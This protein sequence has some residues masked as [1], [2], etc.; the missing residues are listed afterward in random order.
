MQVVK[1]K[2]RVFLEASVS[3]EFHDASEGKCP[4]Q[5]F[6]ST[7]SVGRVIGF[8]SDRGKEP[9]YFLFVGGW[10]VGIVVGHHTA[11]S[12]EF[13]DMTGH[14]CAVNMSN[15]FDEYFKRVLSLF[16]ESLITIN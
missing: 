12:F 16:G 7:A 5:L 2:V 6:V 13:V 3:I 8:L 10:F 1:L 15:V 4:V 9:V 14:V 11:N